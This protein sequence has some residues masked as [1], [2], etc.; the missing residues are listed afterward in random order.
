MAD[1]M[2]VASAEVIDVPASLFIAPFAYH[3]KDSQS[4]IGNRVT[5]MHVPNDM[6]SF[7]YSSHQSILL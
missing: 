1:G 5:Q 7:S 2:K 4:E 6:Q 3:I